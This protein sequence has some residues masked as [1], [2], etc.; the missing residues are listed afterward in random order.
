MCGT[1]FHNLA[2]FSSVIHLGS[3]PA[4]LGFILRP[5]QNVRRHT[6][7]NI[8][9]TGYYTINHVHSKI[10]EQGHYTSAK[11]EKEISEFEQCGLTPEFLNNFHAPFVQESHLKIGMKYLESVPIASNNTIMVVGEIEHLMLPE[12]SLTDEGYLDLE[13]IDSVGISGLNS[14]Y[15]LSKINSFPYARANEIPN[16]KS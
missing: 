15:K 16:F 10:A 11:L 8:L 7:E 1:Q 4:L 13:V 6:Y 2:I 9:E 3:H 14:Y 12:Q 5:N